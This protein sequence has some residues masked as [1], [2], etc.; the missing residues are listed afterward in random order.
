MDE[1]A[2]SQGTGRLPSPAHGLLLPAHGLPLRPA[3]P[4]AVDDVQYAHYDELAQLA[5]K[6]EGHREEYRKLHF[7]SPAAS[8]PAFVARNVQPPNASLDD[9][10]PPVWSSPY[11]S[12][13]RI[14][15]PANRASFAK[16]QKTTPGL[17]PMDKYD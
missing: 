4:P 10:P 1:D 13:N 17:Q 7:G 15:T 16:T 11:G 12:V 5:R 14:P 2:E 6:M 3:L 8:Q 9:Q